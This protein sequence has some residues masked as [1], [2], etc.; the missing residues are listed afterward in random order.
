M[1]TELIKNPAI[2]YTEIRNNMFTNTRKTAAAVH[3]P[4]VRPLDG[5]VRVDMHC[6]S[7]FS[8]GMLTPEQVAEN[9]SACGVKYAALTDHD[10]LDGLPAFRQALRRYGIGLVTGV[11]IT[12]VY[13]DYRVHIL[14]YGFDP[15]CSELITLL[16]PKTGMNETPASIVP[17]YFPLASEV[18][19][20]IHRAGG[21][22]V[23]AHPFQTEPDFEKLK[24]LTEDMRE[25]G[26][27]GIEAIYGP[28]HPEAEAKLLALASEKE[29]IISAGTDYHA[30][31]GS[32]PGVDIKTEQWKSFRDSVIRVSSNHAWKKASFSPDPP[33]RSKRLWLSFTANILIPAVLSLTLFSVALFFILLP[34]FEETLLQRKRENIRELTQVA[35]GVLNE[36]KEEVEN[37][38]LTL[39]HA[40]EFAKNRIEAMRYGSENKDYFWLQDLSP[41]IL[42]H[43]YRTDLNGQDVSDFRDREGRRI[44]VAFADLVREQGEGY[45]SYVWQ[46]MDDLDRLEPKESYIRLFEPWGWVIGTGI[47]VHDVEAEMANFRGHLIKMSLVIIAVV[48]GLLIYLVRQGLVLEKSR[49]NAEKL[50]H[51]SIERYRALS[52]AATEGALF[53]YD[54]RCR[55]ANTVMYELLG[56]ASDTIELLD[57]NDIFPD[58]KANKEW[59]NRLSEPGNNESSLMVNGVLK[60]CDGEYLNCTLSIRNEPFEN[61]SGFMILVRRTMEIA[62][63]TGT[64]GVLNKL[65]QLPVN[66]ASDLTGSIQNAHRIDEIITLCRRTPNWAQALL[67]NGTSSIVVTNMV[68]TITDAAAHRIIELFI[69]EA[70]PP[71]VSYVFLAL[72]SH[73]RLS[74]TLHSDQDNAI[75]YTLTAED[76]PEEAQSYFLELAKYVCD[77]LE[78]AGFP[79][80]IG[81]KVASNPQWCKPLSVWKNCFENWIRSSEPQQVVD[82]SILFDFRPISGDPEIASDLR[83]YISMLLHETPFFLSQIAQNALIFKTPMRLFGTIVTSGGKG[84]PG[85]I[86]V[87]SPA[88]AIVSFARLYALQQNLHETNT[89]LRLDAVRQ[90]GVMLD[91]RHRNIVSA[92]ETLLRLRLWNQVL[93]IKENRQVDHW[94]DPRQ[95]G[96]MEEVV[97]RECFKEIDELQSLIQRDFLA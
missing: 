84:H 60:R 46:W 58:I 47:Y 6:H 64:Q 4:G 97:L 87:K 75:I 55:Y 57:I 79:K 67:E 66:V 12:S 25:L 35:W 53:V 33:R 17:K 30:S 11:E 49:G 95:L 9:L 78:Q 20:L 65:L 54:G 88:M 39:E 41:R 80:C 1:L 81:G 71:P 27:D 22:A 90:A 38:Q 42:M 61:N 43:P 10:T 68:S 70:G 93:A 36:A 94:V 48:L 82:F 21:L 40:Q 56:S 16:K 62:E 3:E 31:N 85:R 2:C 45:V 50:L 18:I 19:D 14:A 59:R 44:F 72:G 32:Q 51:E 83:N 69:E 37:N 77:T 76:D 8:D 29:L 26:I 28:N 91:S 13:G 73:G 92:Y 74:Q 96:H 5:L 7:S 24:T 63:H 89:L 86:D 15:D 52:E 34:Y 23:I